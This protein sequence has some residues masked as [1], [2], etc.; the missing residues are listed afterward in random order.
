MEPCELQEA[1]GGD[2]GYH[3][4]PIFDPPRQDRKDFNMSEATAKCSRSDRLGT[5]PVLQPGDLDLLGFPVSQICFGELYAILRGKKS[6][7]AHLRL[8][9]QALL[10]LEARANI[11]RLEGR[12]LNPDALPFHGTLAT[13]VLWLPLG[14]RQF[15]GIFCV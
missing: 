3:P 1:F 2:C 13:D 14:L 7:R 15:R 9:P 4:Q 10:D 6:W 11:G 8:S 12:A 5:R